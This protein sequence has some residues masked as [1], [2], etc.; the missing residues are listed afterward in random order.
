MQNH[1]FLYNASPR[2]INP[3]RFDITK[4]LRRKTEFSI[5][6]GLNQDEN[7]VSIPKLKGK[8]KVRTIPKKTYLI[9]FILTKIN[10]LIG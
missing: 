3:A 7:P 1:R 10:F 2:I 5:K 8:A 6:K 4:D 9:V